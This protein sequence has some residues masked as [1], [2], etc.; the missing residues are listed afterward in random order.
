MNELSVTTEQATLEEFR[1]ALPNKLK[2]SLSISTIEQMYQDYSDPDFIENM[3]HNFVFFSDVIKGTKYTVQQYLDACKYVTFKK[4]GL[5]NYDAFVKTFPEKYARYVQNGTSSAHIHAYVSS[6]NSG[7]LVNQILEQMTIAPAV[8]YQEYFHK[9]LM[10]QVE[11]M[12]DESVSA[13]TRSDAAAHIMNHTRPPEVKKME[14]TMGVAQDSTVDDLRTV[15]GELADRLRDNIAAGNMTATQA[16][17]M[18]VVSVQ[19]EDDE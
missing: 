11:L 3:K 6:Y 1:D 17:E 9:A 7:K 15:V 4:M 16:A 14:V 13:K 2:E 18:R 12:N 10:V 8:I 5:T 19:G